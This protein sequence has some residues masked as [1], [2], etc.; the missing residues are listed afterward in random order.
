MSSVISTDLLCSGYDKTQILYS[1]NFAA[2]KQLTA[3]IGSNGSGKSTLLKSI[4]GLCDIF[5]GHITLNGQDI[6]KYPAHKLADMGIAYMPQKDNVFADLTV[7]ENL[8]IANISNKTDF[9]DIW[10]FFSVLEPYKKT[11][12]KNLSGGERQ[13]LAMSMILVKSPDVILLDEPTA[14]LSPKNADMILAKIK[15]IQ[16][17]LNCCIILVEQ[18]VKNALNI[19][20]ECYL[21]SSGK[22]VYQ[23]NP[24]KLLSDSN[25]AQ[26]YLGVK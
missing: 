6:T 12:A 24:Q 15:E 21:F 4:F 17:K 11:K 13:L 18:N 25:L 3:I 26:K 16:H 2:D 20:D 9:E 7:L 8:N 19:C 22:I 1:V 5:S 23:G 10:N 14:N